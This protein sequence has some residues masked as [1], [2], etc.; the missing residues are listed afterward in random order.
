M[1]KSRRKV[2]ATMATKSIVR[3]LDRINRRRAMMGLTADQVPRKERSD[4]VNT[5]KET[6]LMMI[7]GRQRSTIT[8]NCTRS[9][10]DNTNRKHMSVAKC[11]EEKIQKIIL[12]VF[13]DRPMIDFELVT[14]LSSVLKCPLCNRI[15]LLT[16]RVTFL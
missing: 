12:K 11:R 1:L 7:A 6:K 5:S 15:D 13:V 4:T 8:E 3:A 2:V 10:K 9:S 16:F 14:A